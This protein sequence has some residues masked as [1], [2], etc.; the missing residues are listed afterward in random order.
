MKNKLIITA[1]A[2]ATTLLINA[3]SAADTAP[4]GMEK[5]KIFDKDGHNMIKIGKSDCGTS[6]HSCAGQGKVYDDEAWIYLNTGAC[7][8]IEGGTTV[9]VIGAAKAKAAELG[10]KAVELKD[11]AIDKTQKTLEKMKS[12][13]A[14]S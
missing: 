6:K 5:C 3:A 4:A 13:E 2:A 8:K 10:E 11:T 12:E 7:D 9:G 1:I 14:K